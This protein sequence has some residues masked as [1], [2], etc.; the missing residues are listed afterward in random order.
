M[1][2]FNRL[3]VRQAQFEGAMQSQLRY[4]TY[5]G[6][7]YALDIIVSYLGAERPPESVFKQDVVDL[8][9]WLKKT[10]NIKEKTILSYL[11][12]GSSFYGWMEDMDY[13]EFNFNPFLRYRRKSWRN[14]P[15]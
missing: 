11:R 6:Y 10:R 5:R 15:S 14:P 3:G 13:I 2:K 12:A 1:D 8:I 7:S 9:E 4:S